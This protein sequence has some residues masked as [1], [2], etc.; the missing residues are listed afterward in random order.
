MGL[1]FVFILSEIAC[2]IFI[3]WREKNPAIKDYDE[4]E[5]DFCK[6]FLP[7]G[8]FILNTGIWWIW[9]CMSHVSHCVKK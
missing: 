7:Y 3:Y 9:Y 5:K 8:L 4:F 1:L 2:L 6:Y